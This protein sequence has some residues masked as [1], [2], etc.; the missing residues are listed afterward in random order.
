VHPESVRWKELQNRKQMKKLTS[1]VSPFLL[2]VLPF[3]V[4]VLWVA[5]QTG[6]EVIQE[7]IQVNASFISLPDTG[8]FKVLLWR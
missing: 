5:G 4:M 6:K 3:F 7:R 1:N 2:L 8:I